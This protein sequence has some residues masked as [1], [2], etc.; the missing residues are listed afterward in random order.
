MLT[1]YRS[2]IAL[3]RRLIMP[4][5]RTCRAE[6]KDATLIMQVPASVPRMIVVAGFPGSVAHETAEGW[7]RAMHADEDGYRISVYERG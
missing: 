4:G 1:W 5:E 7:K 6:W 2:L 3:R